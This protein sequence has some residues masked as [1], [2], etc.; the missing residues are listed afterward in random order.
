MMLPSRDEFVRLAA[1]HDVVPV[2]REVYADLATPISRVH[3]A[4][5]GR[6]AR[7]PARERRRRRA[8]RPLQ[9][10]GRRRPR[11]HHARAA[12]RSSS[13]TA[14]CTGERAD[15]PLRVVRAQARRPGASRACPACRSSSAAPSA[16]SATRSATGFEKV[17]RHDDRRARRAG[18]RASC[19]PTSSWRST[20]RAASCRSSRRCAPAARPSSRTTRRSR[21]ST[22]TS[23]ASTPGPRGAGSAPSACTRRGAARR[24]HTTREEFIAP[25]RAR[26]GAHRRGRHLPG[27]ALA[28][29]LGAVRG[30]R[31]RPVPRAARGE[32]EPVHVLRPHPRRDARG[33]EPRAARARRGRRRCSRARSPAR[34]RAASTAAEDGRLRA[35]LL[36]DEKERAEH[37]MLVDLGRNDLGRVSRAGHGDGRRAHGG[38]V[39]Q[40]RHA[41]RL[42]T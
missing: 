3:G 29:L 26:Q 32:P 10:P 19:S 23:R 8:A 4:R 22:A 27:R 6:R 7:V 17:P 31:A 28:A 24:E 15:D 20:T 12:T 34:V 40:P 37:V 42:A 18:L 33:L 36:A 35:D 2:A 30:R 14:A 1:D 16:S 38:R 41:H 25:V 11:G 13:R 39:L 5:R 21:A 9:L